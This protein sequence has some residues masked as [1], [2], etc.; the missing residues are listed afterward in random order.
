MSIAA[1]NDFFK[2]LDTNETLAKEFEALP[3]DAAY[4]QSVIDLAKKYNFEFTLD[5]LQTVINA[6]KHIKETEVS[7]SK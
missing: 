5:E 3:T 4:K 6:A 2:S 7:E 1:I